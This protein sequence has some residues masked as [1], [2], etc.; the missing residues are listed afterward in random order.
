MNYMNYIYNTSSNKAKSQNWVETKK[1]D[2]KTNHQTYNI[3]Y[4]YV[5]RKKGKD[6]FKKKDPRSQ[7]YTYRKT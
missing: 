3:M 4:M 7:V 2:Q 1:I 5:K 6:T